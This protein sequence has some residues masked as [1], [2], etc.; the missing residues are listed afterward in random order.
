MGE[1]SPFR[2]L[3]PSSLVGN[4]PFCW[5]LLHRVTTTRRGLP[6]GIVRS[7]AH[8]CA[9]EGGLVSVERLGYQGSNMKF[10]RC[11]SFVVLLTVIALCPGLDA[12]GAGFS[13]QGLGGLPGSTLP[14]YQ[15]FALSDDGS[16]V[17][18]RGTRHEGPTEAF[19]WTQATGMVALNV[20]VGSA[21]A[22]GVSADGSV[23]VGYSGGHGFRWTQGTGGEMLFSGLAYGVSDD[24]SVVVGTDGQSNK[25]LRW[26][27]GALGNGIANGVSGD[28]QVVVGDFS[29]GTVR[30]PFHW[31]AATG[32]VE[33]PVPGTGHI[34]ALAANYD[35]SIIVGDG[36]RW[37]AT[38]G[39]VGIGGRGLAMSADGNIIVGA[40]PTI[41][42]GG[43]M[44]HATSGSR[45][46]K[47]MFV[48]LGLPM[49]NWASL[50]AQLFTARITK[51]GLRRTMYW[52]T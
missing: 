10:N 18:G 13:F 8:Q 31:T 4:F 25:A 28:G 24:G 37:S 16:T 1:R 22:Y 49:S 46:L 15:A 44:W 41:T 11:V 39:T 40:N 27:G 32:I 48:D 42:T 6:C 47:Q 26:P 35:G 23:V 30:R 29:N 51:H 20:P 19:R 3:S 45:D 33:L 43:F 12:F 2:P 50:T 36:F 14:Y 7:H 9:I 52:P 21:V 17:V 38:E 5:H 34:S